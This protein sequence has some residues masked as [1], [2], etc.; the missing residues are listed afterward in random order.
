MISHMEIYTSTDEAA[1]GHLYMC[2]KKC[3]IFNGAADFCRNNVPSRCCLSGLVECELVDLR[4]RAY[5]NLDDI[6]H[7][8][9]PAHSF[10]TT[11]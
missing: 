4:H 2:F 5:Q 10:L 9:L 7:R 3:I 11:V 8:Q 1:F 6:L